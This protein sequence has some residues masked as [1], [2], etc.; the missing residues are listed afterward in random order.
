MMRGDKVRLNALGRVKALQGFRNLKA[1]TLHG[2]GEVYEPTSDPNV[3]G[4]KFPSVGGIQF[5][6]ER[7]LEVQ[8]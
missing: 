2:V 4:I 1:Q 8:S 6:H 5:W 3:W 7:Y